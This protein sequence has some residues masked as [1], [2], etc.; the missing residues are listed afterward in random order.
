[1]C[2]ERGVLVGGIWWRLEWIRNRVNATTMCWRP[3][4][5]VLTLANNGCDQLFSASLFL[6][7]EGSLD[8]HPDSLCTH[9]SQR[10]LVCAGF[11]L[12]VVLYISG[13]AST[14]YYHLCGLGFWLLLNWVLIGVALPLLITFKLWLL[15]AIHVFPLLTRICTHDLFT[16]SLPSK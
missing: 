14:H 13:M 6:L 11:P 3:I 15:A 5:F 8:G 12:G 16:S 2:E 1:M 4:M 9:S 7:G 10:A